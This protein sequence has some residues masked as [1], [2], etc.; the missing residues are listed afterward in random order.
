MGSLSV[1]VRLETVVAPTGERA[2]NAFTA[3]GSA[4][5]S[6]LAHRHDGNPPGLAPIVRKCD[7]EV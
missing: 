2:A 1:R 4:A 7:D 5:P 6:P 3:T